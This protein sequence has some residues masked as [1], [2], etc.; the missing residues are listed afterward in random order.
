[1]YYPSGF[2]QLSGDIPQA[3]AV[4]RFMRRRIG[5]RNVLTPSVSDQ[6]NLSSLCYSYLDACLAT[7]GCPEVPALP[8]EELAGIESFPE[9][10]ITVCGA[11]KYYAVVNS[12]KGGVCRIFDRGS[13]Q[14]AYEDSGYRIRSR[15]KI[16]SSQLTG[17]GKRTGAPRADLV[18]AESLFAE[19]SQ[20]VLT[21]G[22][23]VLLR[24]LN[25]TVFR[26]LRMA[27][28]I[29]RRVIGRLTTGGRPGP[30]RLSRTIEFLPDEVRITDE[31]HKTGRM[32]VD[33]LALPRGWT[34]IHM[35]SAKYFYA[36]DLTPTPGQDLESAR[37]SLNRSGSARTGNVVHFESSGGMPGGQA[38]EVASA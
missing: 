1:L 9:S 8:C 19:V 30:F 32:T 18:I 35:G 34:P 15:G 4:A 2:E 7:P 29:R 37:G 33:E 27:N 6:E 38:V 26:S 36:S 24:L 14:V 5:N 17:M 28:W 10:G 3:A 31:L 22:K 25:L 12:A 11:Q 13:N 20:P 21:P 23:F 16:Y